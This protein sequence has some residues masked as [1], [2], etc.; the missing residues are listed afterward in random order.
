MLVNMY[1]AQHLACI[2]DQEFDA[3][4]T[5]GENRFLISVIFEKSD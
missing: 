5:A 2:H 3:L 4:Q 1:K